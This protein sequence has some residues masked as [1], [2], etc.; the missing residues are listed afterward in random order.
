M[1]KEQY[2]DDLFRVAVVIFTSTLYS[3]SVIWFLEPANLI[4]IGITAVG[5]IL[6]RPLP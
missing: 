2:L 4:A 1:N 3:L 5:Q 6:N